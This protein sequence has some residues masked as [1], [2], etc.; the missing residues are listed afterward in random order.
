[1]F[2]PIRARRTQQSRLVYRA[3]IAMMFNATLN[4]ISVWAGYRKHRLTIQQ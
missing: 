4:T 1:M 2:L 3:Y